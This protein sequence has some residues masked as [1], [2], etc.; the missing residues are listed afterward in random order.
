MKILSKLLIV[1]ILCVL[2]MSVGAESNTVQAQDYV[3]Y[4]FSSINELRGQLGV[5]PYT[6]NGSLSAAAINQAQ[7]MV[8]TAQIS[9]TQTNG[10]TPRS[11]AQAAGYQ[12]TWV[13]ENIYMGTNAT[14]QSAWTWWLNSPIHYAGIT[15]TN[16]S[17]VGIGSATGTHGQAF[18][19]VFGNPGG[20]APVTLG[21]SNTSSGGDAQAGAF[22]QPPFVLGTDDFG[23]IMHEVQPGHTLGEIALIYGYTWDD[24]Q[25]IRD[26][27]NLTEAEGRNL[28]IGTV[29]LV[30]SQSGTY[31]PTPESGEGEEVTDENPPEGD[32]SD[33][34]ITPTPDFP[35]ITLAPPTPT[36]TQAV[37]DGGVV[38]SAVVPEWAIETETSDGL[39]PP[40]QTQVVD[41]PTLTITTSAEWVAMTVTPQSTAVAMLDASDAGGLIEPAIVDVNLNDD[42]GG[43]D[44]SAILYIVVALQSVIIGG[45]A[46][47]F[48]RRNQK[49][50]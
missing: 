28:E 6:L 44:D 21:S 42:S 23:N 5:A 38:T 2:S 7:W 27:N 17:E 19:L 31:T 20:I 40:E 8:E 34:N 26:L 45:A 4:L 32:Q 36:Q 10:S 1:T 11:R 37:N 41:A 12:S 24:L 48:W 50:E 3:T 49:T 14:A 15:S 35:V 22:V 9:H 30:P 16:Y 47:E 43:G 13:S 18:V 46:F 39:I 29:L 33:P 25:A